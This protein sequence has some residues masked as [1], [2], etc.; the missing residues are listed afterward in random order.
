MTYQ[1]VA[2]QE[3]AEWGLGTLSSRTPGSR[4]YNYDSSAGKG[5]FAYIID[6][7]LYVEHSE[8]EGRA[9][10]GYNVLEAQGWPFEDTDG[11]GSHVAG[12]IGGKT[13]GVAK[14]A[15]LVSVKIMHNGTTSARN[16]LTGLAWAAQ[17]IIDK[18][19]VGK[20]VINM[21]LGTLGDCPPG[22]VTFFFFLNFVSFVFLHSS[23]WIC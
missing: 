23:S 11:H 8:F 7:G 13:Y 10:L 12:T 15:T 6:T 14:Q 18:G 22:P 1:A 19:R 2:S 5:G 16:V 4:L 3:Q 20:A 21:S 9:E 17:D